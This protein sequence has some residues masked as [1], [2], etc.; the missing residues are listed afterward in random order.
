MDRWQDSRSRLG[1][2][3]DDSRPAVGHA[4]PAR[5]ADATALLT[6]TWRAD[7]ATEGTVYA[8]KTFGSPEVELRLRSSLSP[9][10][11]TGYEISNSVSRGDSSYLIIVRWNG[12]L[13]DFTYLANLRGP[14][15]GVKSGDVVKATIVGNVITAYKN[16]VPL[17]QVKDN[18]FSAGSPGMGFN[19]GT[20]GDYGFTSFKA[21]D[22]S[23]SV[24][25]KW[26]N[27]PLTADDY[28]P[29]AVWLQEPRNA[30]KYKAAGFNLYV[31]LWEGPTK[32]QLDALEAAGMPVICEQNALGLKSKDRKIIVGWMHGDEPDN[33]QS[34]PGGKG[35]GPPIAPSKII[36]DYS[37][38]VAADPT[39]PVMLNLGQGVAY[40]NYIGRGVRRNKPQDY[41]QYVKGC[42]IVSFDI[43]PVTH[44][45][46][47]VAGK[48]WFVPRG[49]DRLRQWSGDKK[50]VWNC[51]ECTHVGNP[52]RKPTPAQIKALVWMSL[53]HGARGLIYF[54]HQFKPKFIEAG[55]LADPET[56]AAVTAI[57]RQIKELAPVLN[58]P[59]LADAVRAESS[60]ATAPIDVMVK[61][62][63][64]P[65]YVFAVA[66]RDKPAEATFTIKA[67]EGLSRVEVLG[68]HRTLE[69]KAGQFVDKF[70]GY[71]V[72]L[73]KITK[74]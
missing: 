17:A 4:G 62:R 5:Y 13:A 56:T 8:G 39:R 69:I 14:Q 21:S 16:G 2:H 71:Q 67:A 49:V 72:H 24:Y 7:Q 34:L 11:A 31:G 58:S 29:I 15:Y 28:F 60:S 66:M 43:Y 1:R 47:E 25:A 68:E 57:N 3:L 26:Q 23:A 64:G 35:Y 52:N 61:R 53:I 33:A 73:Y 6:G 27:G 70:A 37:K 65:L 10:S 59:T 30:A 55:L 32:A 54:V 36:A 44:D 19:E 48:L 9:H 12:R 20:N 50:I 18:T 41:A 42:D 51:I 38:L 63:D 45:T 74:P 40:D 22:S 46:A